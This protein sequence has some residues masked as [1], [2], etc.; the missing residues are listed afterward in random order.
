MQQM[1]QYQRLTEIHQHK[2]N[3]ECPVFDGGD[4]TCDFEHVPDGG[5]GSEFPQNFVRHALGEGIVAYQALRDAGE[6]PVDPMQMGI[7]AATDDHNGIPG[8]VAEE[9]WQGHIG[10]TD[11]TPAG[12]LRE[13]FHNPGGVTGLWAEQNTR[14]AIFA[15]LQRRETFGTSGPRITLRFY[16]I[17]TP[18]SYCSS[19]ASGGGFPGNIL[20]AG[21]VPMGGTMPAGSATANFVV[22][23]LQDMTALV[24]VDIIR[25]AV[26]DGTV[27]ETIRRFTPD[28]SD[29]NWSSGSACIQWTDPDFDPAM[30]A[31]YYV[32]VLQAPTWRWSHYDCQ[33]NPA[34]AACAPD[35]GV[36][37]MIQER[38]WSSPIWW[39][40]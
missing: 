24:E 9:G 18:A 31:Y 14:D 23:A 38:A 5:G 29:T 36:D 26:V 35:G 34:N 16:E 10:D 19:T 32:R 21:G 28:S 40:P 30:P 7:E 11:D 13:W 12:R 3:S 20:A 17:S 6:T 25:G 4:P 33:T 37:V 8:Y 22:S 15:A 27:K 1:N 39:L 2:G